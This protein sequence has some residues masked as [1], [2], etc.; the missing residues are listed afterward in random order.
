MLMPSLLYEF[1]YGLIRF[2]IDQNS[3]CTLLAGEHL[4][5]DVNSYA[6]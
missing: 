3:F 2:K 6:C 5:F 4:L 1:L